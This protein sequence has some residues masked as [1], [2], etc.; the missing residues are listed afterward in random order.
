[1]TTT[2]KQ[3]IT[4]HIIILE[5]LNKRS[6]K[7]TDTTNLPYRVHVN[8]STTMANIMKEVELANATKF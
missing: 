2:S 1:M 5:F 6:F 4:V 7:P 3:V 8:I